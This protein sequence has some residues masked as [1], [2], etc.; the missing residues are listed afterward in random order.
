MTLCPGLSNWVIAR[1]ERH[2]ALF[3]VSK[4]AVS[5]L[6]EAAEETARAEGCAFINLFTA[7]GGDGTMGR[8][9]N[10]KPKLVSPDLGH[11]LNPGAIQVGNLLGAMLLDG[12]QQHRD[13]V[14]EK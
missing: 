6:V 2:S 10:A 5:K 7:M 1:P 4:P 13:W 12:Y 11:I 14:E 8:W 9:Y 3:I